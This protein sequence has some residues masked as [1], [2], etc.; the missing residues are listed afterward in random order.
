VTTMKLAPSLAIVIIAS[1]LR[2]SL[3]R[4][5]SDPAIEHQ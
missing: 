2:L 3:G 5:G 4:A 1:I